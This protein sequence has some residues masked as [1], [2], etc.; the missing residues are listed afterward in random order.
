MKPGTVVI[1]EFQ[2]AAAVKRRLA[3][4][5]SSEAY[6]RERA[7]AILCVVT[8]EPGESVSPTDYILQDWSAAGLKRPSTIRIFP[9]TLPQSNLLGVGELSERDWTKVR[10]RLQIALDF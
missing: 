1:A 9:F 2:G 5:V 10:T 4:V 8:A 3:V 7:E 6:Q